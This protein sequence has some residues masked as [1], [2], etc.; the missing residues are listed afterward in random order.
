MTL[1]HFLGII[2][3][4]RAAGRTLS[5]SQH[6]ERDS[7]SRSQHCHPCSSFY[8]PDA[9]HPSLPTEC[10]CFSTCHCPT[11]ITTHNEGLTKAITAGKILVHTL[12]CRS[13]T[14]TKPLP[15]FWRHSWENSY[16]THILRSPLIRLTTAD[17][18]SDNKFVE[19]N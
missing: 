9:N 6:A 7:A 5:A 16:A 10:V 15:N 19:A 12:L 17:D 18:S 4:L 14:P 2:F 11:Q 8:S 13:V 1:G 3:L